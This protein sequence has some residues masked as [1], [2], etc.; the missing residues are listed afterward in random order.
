MF[1]RGCE[2][3]LSALA[4]LF[5]LALPGSCL[6][7]LTYFFWEHCTVRMTL[8]V[9]DSVSLFVQ[10]EEDV[11]RGGRSRRRRDADGAAQVGGAQEQPLEGPP[12]EAPQSRLFC[13]EAQQVTKP[14]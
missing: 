8:P 4:Y 6:A 5:C 2:K 12:S 7:R 1:V 14:Q 10:G 13:R 3:C 11:G 9:S